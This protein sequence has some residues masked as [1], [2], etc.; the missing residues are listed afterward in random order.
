M[1]DD[2]RN[3]KF[4]SECVELDTKIIDVLSFGEISISIGSNLSQ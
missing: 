3:I 1:M 4:S 2:F